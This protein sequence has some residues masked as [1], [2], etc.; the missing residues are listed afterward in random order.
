MRS[1]FKTQVT[2]KNY[3][4]IGDNNFRY[5]YEPTTLIE[6]NNIIQ[7]IRA[8]WQTFNAPEPDKIY[9]YEAKEVLVTA[10]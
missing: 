7:E 10:K 9:I 5:P 6:V 8:Y 4:I 3:I 1:P 2:M